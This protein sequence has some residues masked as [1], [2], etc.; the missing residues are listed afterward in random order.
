MKVRVRPTVKQTKELVKMPPEGMSVDGTDTSLSE[1]PNTSAHPVEV[2][3][4][5]YNTPET[6]PTFPAPYTY[7]LSPN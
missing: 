6:C 3:S 1:A 4:G 2:N 5:Q 7:T